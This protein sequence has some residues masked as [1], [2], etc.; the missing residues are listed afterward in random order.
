MWKTSALA[1]KPYL[2]K[3]SGIVF[4]H[5]KL[6]NLNG[7]ELGIILTDDKFI[8][9]LNKQF[10]K[11]DKPT[12]VLSFPYITYSNKKKFSNELIGEVFISYETLKRETKVQGKTL[13][14][15]FT[16]LLIHSIL[17]LFG[18]DHMK[19]REASIMESLEVEILAKLGIN[20][21][22]IS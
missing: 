7:C 8:R 18:Y 4:R 14:D 9:Q 20:N 22:Y 6:S 17:H 2:N 5:L 16:H 1:K 3:I 12:N 19:S 10:R 21:P 15:H 13:K 11:K